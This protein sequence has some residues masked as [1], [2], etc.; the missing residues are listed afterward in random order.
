MLRVICVGMV[1]RKD[2]L[3]CSKGRQR[4]NCKRVSQQHTQ[5]KDMDNRIIDANEELTEAKAWHE[6]NQM[7]EAMNAGIE[8]KNEMMK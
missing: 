4:N 5:E 6:M 3:M 8:D 7:S 2:E 1:Q